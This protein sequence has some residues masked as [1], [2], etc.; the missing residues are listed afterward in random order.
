MAGQAL[1]V[2]MTGEDKIIAALKSADG[3]VTIRALADKAGLRSPG[4]VHEIL[5]RLEKQ[6]LIRHVHGYEWVKP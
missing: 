2:G 5:G 4:Y 6:G 1:S 3:A